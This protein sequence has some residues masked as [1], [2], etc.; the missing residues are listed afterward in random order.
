[1]GQAGGESLWMCG[2]GRRKH[3]R[4][5]RHA[6]VGESVMHV[7][8]RQQRNDERLAGHGHDEVERRAKSKGEPTAPGTELGDWITWARP[9]ADR[10]DALK[11]PN[12]EECS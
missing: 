10:L 3:S 9:H 12:D 4:S 11:P 2:V 7:V 6:L 8:G 1:M 5:R